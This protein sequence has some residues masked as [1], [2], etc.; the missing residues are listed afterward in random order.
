MTTEK[1]PAA[2]IAGATPEKADLPDGPNVGPSAYEHLAAQGKVDPR[3]V[4]PGGSGL[5]EP[6]PRSPEK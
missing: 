1:N 2:P 5:P 6:G 4:V 3:G